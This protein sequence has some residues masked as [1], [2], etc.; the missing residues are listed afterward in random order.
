[1]TDCPCHALQM[2]TRGPQDRKAEAKRKKEQ[3]ERTRMKIHRKQKSNLKSTKQSERHKEKRLGEGNSDQNK[4]P[5]ITEKPRMVTQPLTDRVDV[6]AGQRTSFTLT[7]TNLKWISLIALQLHNLHFRNITLLLRLVKSGNKV[8]RRVGG[9]GGPAHST[10]EQR[11]RW[12]EGEAPSSPFL[13]PLHEGTGLV[14][15]D[16]V[17]LKNT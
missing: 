14:R 15:A 9:G 8:R 2:R 12:N 10:S 13:P 16:D 1:M 4:T 11:Q 5:Q 17:L 3:K 6:T 7:Q